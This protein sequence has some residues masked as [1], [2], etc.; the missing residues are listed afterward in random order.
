MTD[1]GF[2]IGSEGSILITMSPNIDFQGALCAVVGLGISNLPLLDWLPA[3]GARVIVYDQKER[4][5]LGPAAKF[6][7]EK[8]IPLIAG[9][10]CL[11]NLHADYI[12]RS[13]GL[14][15]D[16]PAF[17]TAVQEGAVLTSE[18]EL[19]LKL[20][21]AN[22]IGITGSDGK[23]TSTTLTHLLLREQARACGQFSAFVGGNIGIPLLPQLERMHAGDFAV[24]E[25]SSFQ[26]QSF[27]QSPQCAA[28]TNLSPN[29]L[30]WHTDMEEYV[31]AKTNIYRHKGNRHLVLNAENTESLRMLQAVPYTGQITWFSSVRT[32]VGA[33][34]KL[35]RPG[36][37]AVYASDGWIFWYDGAETHRFLRIE[38]IRVPG[39][40]NLEN[41]MTAIALTADR[42]SP[43]IAETV[44]SSFQG[45][46]HRLELVRTVNGVRYYNSSIDSTPSRTAAALSALRERPIVICGGYD[47]NLSFA[48]LAQIL[49]QRAKA[50]VLTGATAEKI[51]AALQEEQREHDETLPIYSESDFT[52]AVHCA[53]RIAE[54]GDTVLLS[55]AC[56]SFDAF[57]NF[58]ERGDTFRRIVNAF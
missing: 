23:T 40:H 48:P 32:S 16:L 9:A 3:H 33:F 36:D 56:A 50:V 58:E 18:T 49:F 6:A 42:I 45:V 38:S 22:V 28:I 19:F 7:E 37:R 34:S 29:H 39:I 43:E 47:K 13:P 52:D 21:P 51:Y 46:S 5:E 55:P 31:T 20:T 14:R 2:E 24:V 12:F 4:S 26:L 27:S 17:V 15:P 41:F 10:D 57:R 30:N 1:N 35:L 53:H 8:R 25:F 44:A 54:R 11:Q